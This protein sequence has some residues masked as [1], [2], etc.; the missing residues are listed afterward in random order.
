MSTPLD[1]ASVQGHLS[2]VQLLLEAGAEKNCKDGYGKS[3]LNLASTNNHPSV[4]SALLAAGAESDLADDNG[5]TPLIRAACYGRSEVA[6]LLLNAGANR[7]LRN[8]AGKTALYLAIEYKRDEVAA[9]LREH[10][11]LEHF[12]RPEVVYGSGRALPCE[13]AEL[14]GDYATLTPARRAFHARASQ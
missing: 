14:C 7:Q 13:L 9:I 5:W 12:V 11:R 3:P 1:I 6:R 10:Q 4:V 8:N 2:C